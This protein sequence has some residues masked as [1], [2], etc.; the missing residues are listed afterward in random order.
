MKKINLF[1]IYHIKNFSDINN[2][3]LKKK[4]PKK[5]INLNNIHYNLN[6]INNDLV[7]NVYYMKNKAFSNKNKKISNIFFPFNLKKDENNLNKNNNNNNLNNKNNNNNNLNDFKNNNNKLLFNK[8]IKTAYDYYKKSKENIDIKNKYIYNMLIPYIKI[9][10]SP[11]NKKS[12][13]NFSTIY[14]TNSLFNNYKTQKIPKKISFSFSKNYYFINK[15]YNSENSNIDNSNKIIVLNKEE[16]NNHFI[17]HNK[18]IKDAIKNIKLK[19]KIVSNSVNNINYNENNNKNINNN[20]INNYLTLDLNSNIN[21]NNNNNIFNNDINNNLKIN[22]KTHFDLKKSSSCGNFNLS[23]VKFNK[24]KIIIKSN[25]KINNIKDNN[26]N[27]L[28]KN[29]YKIF[30]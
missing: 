21:N 12:F 27:Y 6:N 8:N 2:E 15:S 10:S 13:S 17:F 28:L 3:N 4:Y 19:Q 18:F 5:F 24:N 22:K 23:N 16:L 25:N 14:K 20:N 26:K 1:D 7:N 9:I 30:K 11:T 29:F